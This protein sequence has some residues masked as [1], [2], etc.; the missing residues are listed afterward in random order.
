[1]AVAHD[2]AAGGLAVAPHVL[3]PRL[4]EFGSQFRHPLAAFR[5]E[6]A[7]VLVAIIIAVLAIALRIRQSRD[8]PA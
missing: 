4:A 3:S 8:D 7:L 6:D 1:M 5:I 2:F